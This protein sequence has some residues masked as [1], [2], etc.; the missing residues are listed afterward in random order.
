MT[1]GPESLDH[2][3]FRASQ[4][5]A[6]RAHAASDEDRLTGELIVQRNQ[7]VVCGEGAGRT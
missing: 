6:A 5:V 2:S 4:N 3:P 1:G 7:R